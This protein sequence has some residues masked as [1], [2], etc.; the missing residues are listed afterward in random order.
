MTNPISKWDLE[1]LRKKYADAI[2]SLKND[3]P[4]RLKVTENELVAIWYFSF[5]LFNS[6]GCVLRDKNSGGYPGDRFFSRCF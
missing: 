2:T 1:G 3:L 6:T 4:S 5:L